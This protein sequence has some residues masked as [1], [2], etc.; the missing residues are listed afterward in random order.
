MA[1]TLTGRRHR[2][3]FFDIVEAADF[4][5]EDVNDDIANINQHPVTGRKPLDARLAMAGFLQRPQDVIGQSPHMAVGAARSNDQGVGDR[6]FA[7]QVD[8]DDVLRLIILKTVENQRLNRQT[9]LSGDGGTLV[10]IG[11]R[12]FG[13]R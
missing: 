7:A 12:R 3:D 8:T 1:R 4:G 5:T 11:R 6:A 9:V 13:G 10:N 2:P